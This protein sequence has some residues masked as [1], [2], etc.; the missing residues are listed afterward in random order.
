MTERIPTA[1]AE[2]IARIATEM[3]VTTSGELLR[4]LNAAWRA[5]YSEGFEIGQKAMARALE[6]VQEA[7]L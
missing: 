7:L 1:Q 6:A 3:P 4:A 5:G 2:A